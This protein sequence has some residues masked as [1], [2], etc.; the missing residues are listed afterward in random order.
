M[1][2]KIYTIENLQRILNK[3]KA[4]GKKIVLC[5]G[6]FDLLHIGHIKH[7]E[8]AKSF[9][10]ILVVSVTP[11]K[12]VNKGPLRPKQKLNTRLQVLN[13][14][15]FIDLIIVFSDKTPLNIINKIKPHLLIKGSDYRENKIVGAKEV[16]KYGGN[17]LRAKILNNFSSS[18]IID[19]ILDTSF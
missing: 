7:F 1:K 19:E 16:K 12:Y 8:E 9:G 17:I 6:V 4:K 11:D 18:I 10:D 2:N 5:H 14:I 15:P 13:S 3:E